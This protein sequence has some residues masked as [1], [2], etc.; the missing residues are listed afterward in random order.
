MT[1]TIAMKGPMVL[2]LVS[3]IGEKDVRVRIEYSIHTRG[4]NID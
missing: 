1:M 3:I 4:I 2:V